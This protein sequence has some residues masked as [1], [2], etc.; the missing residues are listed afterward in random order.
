M[1]ESVGHNIEDLVR[2]ATESL[3]ASGQEA[4]K[5]YGRRHESAK[6][7]QQLVTEAEL[8]LQE[9]FL[10]RLQTHYPEHQLFDGQQLEKGYTH[11]QRRYLWI[12]DPL[13]GV[14]NF[15]AGIPVWGAS[16][17][18]LENF[19]P[20]FGAF[21][22]PV[23]GDLFQARAG[24]EAL[25]GNHRVHV[26]RQETI[27]DESVLMVYSRFQQRYRST[28]PG[29]VLN[30]GCTGAHICQVAMGFAEAAFITNE[31]YQD[32]A[33]ASVIVEAAGGRIYRMDAKPLRLNE[34][35]DDAGHIPGPFLATSEDL[36][37]QVLR[38]IQA[39][40]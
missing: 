25:R 30:M 32:L 6:F 38:H 18:L 15:S 2:F 40:V 16:L 31:S 26:S 37:S 24:G 13:D 28:F 10:H 22:M 7:D 29:K 23:T 34:Y 9:H 35:L 33:A 17:A 4:I 11:A 12:F 3:K 21:Y 19:W 39:A 27:N 14:S 8:H 20:V 36:Q 1:A 5:F